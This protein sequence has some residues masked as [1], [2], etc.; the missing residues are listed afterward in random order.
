[1]RLDE[2]HGGDDEVDELDANERDDDPAQ[3][4]NE[5]VALKHGEGADGRVFDAAQGQG[6]Q[7]DNDE[8]VENDGA[9]DGAGGAVQAHDVKGRN[10]RERGHQ[11]GG[12]DGE[13][14]GD[15]VGDAERSERAAC[16][17]ELL[18]D[19]DDLDELGGVAVQVHHVA[20]LAVGGGP[21]L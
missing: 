20:R 2:L 4:V 21:I 9:Q 6:N 5:Q 12:D 3:A 19:F 16:D 7:R 1:M 15:V 8:G 10:G 14:F 18:P 13:V 17:K 11:H